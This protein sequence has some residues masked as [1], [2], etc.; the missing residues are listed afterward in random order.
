M[1]KT[2]HL[3]HIILIIT[4]FFSGCI[5]NKNNGEDLSK[6]ETIPTISGK[7]ISVSDA[8]IHIISAESIS[9]EYI[10]HIN[11]NTKFKEGISDVFEKGNYVIIEFNGN[12]MESF[13]MQINAAKIIANESD[14]N[15]IIEDKLPE[16]ILDKNKTEAEV[17]LNE[18]FAIKLE[19][20]PSTGYR[21]IY[22]LS[23]VNIS[24]LYDEFIVSNPD[25]LGSPGVHYWGFEIDKIGEYYIKF[26]LISPS[27][28]VKD[29]VT[30]Q[31][32]AVDE[33]DTGYIEHTGT[34]LD[35]K[36]ELIE[37]HVEDMILSIYAPNFN[38]TDY[39][40][41]DTVFFKAKKG[42]AIVTLEYIE[43]KIKYNIFSGILKSINDVNIITVKSDETLMMF[44][45]SEDSIIPDDL[46]IGDKIK[47]TYYTDYISETTIITEIDHIE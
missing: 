38:E 9:D 25:L 19:E 1:Q 46:E 7:I 39:N 17:F 3:L 32:F 6:T 28:E 41:G 43:K 31:I 23:S 5:F 34:Y 20:N 29:E 44:A 26:K 11:K 36:N 24:Q 14:S 18:P 30:F 2:L 42:E 4:L 40:K 47:V 37:I 16:T 22:E 33:N 10:V 15:L 21:Y 12:I 45:I 27:N 35:Y 13:P 8:S